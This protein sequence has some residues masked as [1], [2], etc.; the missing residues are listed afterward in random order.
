MQDRFTKK[1]WIL[2]K[3]RIADW[4][5][6]YMDKLN[7][8]YIELLSGDCSPSEKFWELDKRIEQDRKKPGVLLRMSRSEFIYNVISLIHDNVI[9]FDDLKD[10]SDELKETVK[11][12]LDRELYDYSDEE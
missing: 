9:S 11:T 1:D 12:F 7:R 8:E 3:T 6:A 2:F 4:Q 10:F 5:E